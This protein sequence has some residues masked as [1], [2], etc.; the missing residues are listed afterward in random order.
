M[1]EVLFFTIVAVIS[2][3]VGDPH[4]KLVTRWEAW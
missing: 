4:S 2:A 1:T 3:R